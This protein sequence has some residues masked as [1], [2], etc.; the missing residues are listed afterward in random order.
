[1]AVRSA[2][3]A[4]ARPQDAPAPV[5]A[6][7]THI[8]PTEGTDSAN[9]A[10]SIDAGRRLIRLAPDKGLSLTDRLANHLTRLM[11]R[12]PLY[13]LRLEG[14]F[15]LRL[16]GTPADPLP[17]DA[18]AGRALR[19]GRIGFRGL[20]QPV[21]TLDF[22]A[23]DQPAA[24]A[25]YLHR[26]GWLRDLAVSGARADGAPV[27]EDI[28]R[29]WLAVHRDVVSVPAW[30]PDNS[31]W[32][33]LA[34]MAHA[35]L[36]LSSSDLV[37]RSAVL[38]HIARAARHLDGQADRCRPGIGQMVAWAAILVVALLIPGNDARRVF[39]EAG[40]RKALEAMFYADGGN[41][42]R[43]PLVQL[44]AAEVLALL[45]RAYELRGEAV[46]AFV[47][48]ALAR[49]LPA[50]AALQYGDGALASWQ[51]SA[52]TDAARV[53][54]IFAA[55]GGR[56]RPLKQA[57]D[58]G[59]Q[60]LKAGR[61]VAVCDA[62]P[63]PVARITDAGCASTLAFEL[64]D[65]PHRL[66]VNCGGAALVGASIP[67]GLARGLRTTAAHSTLVVQDANST[68][69]LPDGSLGRGVAE[70]EVERRETAEASRL[71]LSHDGYVRGFG[72]IHRRTLI[73]LPSGRELRGEDVLTPA[74]RARRRRGDAPFCLRFHLG[75]G[76]AASLTADGMAAL[77]RITGGPMWQFRTSDGQL[78]IEDSLWV[79]GNG[80][81]HPTQQL[82][83]SAVSPAGGASIGWI[84][85][86]I[87]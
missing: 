6:A 34:W 43:S 69:I 66:V 63:P 74:A 22:A 71:D 36:I 61:V 5:A 54:A 10:D 72:L 76:V 18:A 3:L 24:F 23:L 85:K 16:L 86:L 44:E 37:Y 7:A 33:I 30:R 11:W 26:F 31:A 49:A 29:K 32:R 81:P 35:P 40:L 14:R 65:G 46:P 8:E 75:H 15:P 53:A 25:D 9:S 80:R 41:I 12:T 27:A 58:W 73:L 13:A 67:A 78:T 17:G 79:D 77:L 38:N 83:V 1:M 56:A 68:A 47:T 70:V 45:I 87:G 51:G 82:V 20:V 4:A 64:A 42:A 28:A 19:A 21:A 2:P 60:Q 39:G 50:L 55:A 57:R 48:E 84:F 52:A 59:Y 62:A